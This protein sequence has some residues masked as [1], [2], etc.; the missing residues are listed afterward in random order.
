MA[1]IEG[2]Q[3]Q[4]IQAENVVRVGVGERH[5]VYDTDPL[6]QQLRPQ[7][8]WCVDQQIAFRQACD[9]RTARPLIP[10][11][12][13]ATDGATAAEVGTPTDVPVPSRMNLP[14]ISLLSGCENHCF[15]STRDLTARRH[16]PM[17]YCIRRRIRESQ[18][19]AVVTPAATAAAT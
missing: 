11:L 13:A 19:C 8:G 18:G 2:K 1:Q 9:G 14:R 3:P 17:T 16:C 4:V 15:A 5:A 6:A 10:R 7:I 12:S